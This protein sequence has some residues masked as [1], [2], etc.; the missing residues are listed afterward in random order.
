LSTLFLI[1]L[2]NEINFHDRKKH[3]SAIAIVLNDRKSTWSN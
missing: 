3:E 2:L 1:K